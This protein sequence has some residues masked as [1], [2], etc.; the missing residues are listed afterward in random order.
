[1]QD[2]TP[3]IPERKRPLGGPSRARRWI[4]RHRRLAVAQLIRG[5]SFATGTTAISLIAVWVQHRG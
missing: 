2:K 4:T 3:G 1:M 5:A